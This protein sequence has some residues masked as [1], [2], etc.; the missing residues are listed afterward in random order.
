MHRRFDTQSARWYYLQ[1]NL[2][3]VRK[4]P[5]RKMDFIK[6]CCTFWNPF[7]FILCRGNACTY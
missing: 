5:N 7:I 6:W 2:V 1:G 3:G 4:E